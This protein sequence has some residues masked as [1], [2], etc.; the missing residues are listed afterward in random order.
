MISPCSASSGRTTPPV[1][2]DQI[3]ITNQAPGGGLAMISPANTWTALTRPDPGERE[4]GFYPSGERNFVRIAA[5]DHLQAVADATLVKELGAQSLFVLSDDSVLPYRRRNG[6]AEPRARD[7]R[8]QRVE[9]RGSQLRPPRPTHR[10]DS[11]RRGVHRRLLLS[12]RGRPGSGSPRPPRSRRGARRHRPSSAPSRTCSRPP[13]RRREGCTSAASGVPNGELPPAGKR[14][15]E[16][17][18]ATREGEP[19]PSSY[20]RVRRPGGRDP[21]RGDRPLRRHARVG[22]TRAFR[23]DHRGR[24]PRGHQVRRVRRPHGSTRDHLP[25]RR[26][27]RPELL[28]RLFQGRCLRSGDHGPC[29][30]PPLS[31]GVRAVPTLPCSSETRPGAHVSHLSASAVQTCRQRGYAPKRFLA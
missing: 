28:G 30:S 10:P 21:A 22:D 11:S 20:R 15:L 14:F 26:Q 17:F 5:A 27:T 12:E 25:R 9:L 24:H 31:E 2:Y 23:D 18:E 3:P 6:G 1:P 13:G 19:S 29:G 4:N 16:E 7:C 8:L